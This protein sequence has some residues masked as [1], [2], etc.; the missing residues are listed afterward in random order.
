MNTTDY[1]T[2]ACVMHYDL[3]TGQAYVETQKKEIGKYYCSDVYIF[4]FDEADGPD[5]KIRQMIFYKYPNYIN[6]EIVG[7]LDGHHP[8][9][10]LTVYKKSKGTPITEDFSK[11]VYSYID[12]GNQYK[13]IIPYQK[14]NLSNIKINPGD[15]LQKMNVSTATKILYTYDSGTG[16]LT[17]NCPSSTDDYGTYELLG[18]IRLTV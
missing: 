14:I 4:Y 10:L 3:K 13:N 12:N 5:Y 17:F 7:D 15:S 6:Q 11:T 8:D 18:D 2:K 1:L 16:E 9:I